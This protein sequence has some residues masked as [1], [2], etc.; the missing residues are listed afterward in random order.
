MLLM[1]LYTG[2]HLRANRG[3][4]PEEREVTMRRSAGE[5]F[6]RANVIEMAEPADDVAAKIVEIALGCEINCY[7]CAEIKA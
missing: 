1:S 5:D 6:N 2:A 3:V 4:S 7:A